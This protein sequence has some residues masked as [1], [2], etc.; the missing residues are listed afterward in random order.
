MCYDGA[1]KLKWCAFVS[2]RFQTMVAQ[3]LLRRKQHKRQDN[4]DIILQGSF[5]F[6]LAWKLRSLT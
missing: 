6:E 3:Y 5:P 2:M 1:D 4:F